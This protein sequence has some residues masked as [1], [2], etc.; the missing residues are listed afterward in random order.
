MLR[1][2]NAVVLTSD[3]FNLHKVLHKNVITLQNYLK[4]LG[5][6]FNKTVC[7][8]ITFVGDSLPLGL[9]I[10]VENLERK[11]AKMKEI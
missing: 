6:C 9:D 7:T 4:T 8:N 5:A 3:F 2:E 1:Y 11:P 10:M